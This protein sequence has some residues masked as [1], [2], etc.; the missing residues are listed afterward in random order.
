M[1]SRGVIEPSSSPWAAPIVLAKKR[2]GSTRFC[3]DFRK[4]NDVTRKDAQPLPRIDD[5]L[6]ALGQARYFSTLDL[7]SGYWQVEVKPGDKEKT[8]F[9]TPHGL[10]QFW[11]MPFGL[12]NAPATFQHLIARISRPALVHMLGIFRGYNRVQ[13][14][15]GRTPG[16][17]QSSTCMLAS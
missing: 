6:D 9:V 4:L 3:I 1:L 16:A 15:S 13:Y 17:S 2:D 11:V 12:C 14:N 8:A 7:A 10:F 5:T